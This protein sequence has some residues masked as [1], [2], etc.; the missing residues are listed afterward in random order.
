[1]V[2][3]PAACLFEDFQY[4]DIQ[5]EALRQLSRVNHPNIVGSCDNPVGLVMEYAE[6]GSLYNVLHS[7]DPQ[8]HSTGSHAMSWC[9]QCAKGVAY[10]HAMKPMALIH[11]D[12]KPPSSHPLFDVN[13]NKETIEATTSGRGRGG[14]L[15][16]SLDRVNPNVGMW[17]S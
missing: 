15:S 13:T 7:A 10:L 5:V 6:C 14:R 2:D 3:S 9:L 12:L 1:M 11:R 4:E 16:N 17:L 8:P